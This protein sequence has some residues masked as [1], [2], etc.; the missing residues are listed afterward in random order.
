[1][2][3]ATFYDH[4]AEMARQESITLAEALKTAKDLGVEALEVLS[5]NSKGK[6]QEIKSDLDAAGLSV[7]SLCAFMDFGKNTDLQA[8]EDIMTSAD[9]LGT[10]RILVIPGFYDKTDSEQEKKEK[11]NQMIHMTRIFEDRAVARGF[12]LVM[13]EFDSVE[14]PISTIDGLNQF[15]SEMHHIGLAFDT[16]N[17]L[18]SEEDE[19]KAM[20]VLKDK[21]VYVHLKDRSFTM[22]DESAEKK[23]TVGGRVMYPSPVGQGVIKLEEIMKILKETGYHGD[24]TIE[25]YGAESQLTYL[26]ES[27][28]W[29]KKH[30][31]FEKKS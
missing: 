10:S 19:L 21:I 2:K 9:R 11:W 8:I 23:A 27:I 12:T 22:S 17:F 14:S 25:H 5:S 24:F 18:Y 16:G 31:F 29:L 20:D 13:E 4:I 30:D 15:L 1:M 7:S 28:D 26:K 6:E 3:I